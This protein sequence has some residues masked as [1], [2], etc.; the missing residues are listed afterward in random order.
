MTFVNLS[1]FKENL[2]TQ[3][4]QSSYSNGLFKVIDAAMYNV[5]SNEVDWNSFSLQEAQQALNEALAYV[6]DEIADE[7]SVRPN[8][9]NAIHAYL[10]NNE[11]MYRLRRMK[12]I[13]QETEDN[14]FF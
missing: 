2:T 1:K 6:A 10:H 7:Y 13:Y 5:E 12:P 4:P 11:S 8:E 9:G 3:Q 14:E